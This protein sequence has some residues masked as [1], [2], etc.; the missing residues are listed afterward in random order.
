MI[1]FIYLLR[2]NFVMNKR[3]IEFNLTTIAVLILIVIGLV[4]LIVFVV[5][6]FT[7]LT[8][9]EGLGKGEQIA[10]QGLLGIDWDELTLEEQAKLEPSQA[11][12]T[13]LN[14]AN[15]YLQNGNEVD[16]DRAKILAEDVLKEPSTEEIRKR[17]NDIMNSV[18]DCKAKFLYENSL[19]QE[20]V[21][22]K[23]NSKDSYVKAKEQFQEVI[24]K[25]S[26]TTY[27]TDSLARIN[28]LD[29]AFGEV[30]EEDFLKQYT[31][32]TPQNLYAVGNYF[33]KK[34]EADYNL[35][36]SN[37]NEN[38]RLRSRGSYKQALDKYADIEI[39]YPESPELKTTLLDQAAIFERMAVIDSLRYNNVIAYGSYSRILMNY[40]AKLTESEKES[41]KNK[42]LTLSKSGFASKLKIELT[43]L[44]YISRYGII[45]N[46]DDQFRD[47]S[48]YPLISLSKDETFDLRPSFTSTLS[49]EEFKAK[50][51]LHED[52]PVWF[53][54]LI[55]DEFDNELCFV[56]TNEDP[57][58]KLKDLLGK[59]ILPGIGC[60][61]THLTLVLA[62]YNKNTFTFKFKISAIP[63]FTNQGLED[64]E[65]NRD[66]ETFGEEIE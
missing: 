42:I 65:K 5:P 1:S 55:K 6:T 23:T 45:Y 64:W 28:A 52:K 17:A 11:D 40:D 38:T 14:T 44:G 4:L 21:A 47:S 19:I 7:K 30:K 9:E 20:K 60:T 33:F 32:P 51:H 50:D 31:E 8:G 16:C 39:Q 25:Y 29:I 2:V 26:A 48:E 35:Y 27:A 61:R 12:D 49:G 24:N 22:Y 57:N 15:K 37:F 54:L 53:Q 18:N 3:G 34:G 56:S 36:T 62:D 63:Y 13:R 43:V 66:K 58:I 46:T 10:K 41:I 59:V